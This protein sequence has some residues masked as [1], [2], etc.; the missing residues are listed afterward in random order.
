MEFDEMLCKNGNRD[1][2]NLILEIVLDFK[3]NLLLWNLSSRLETGLVM[4]IVSGYN[5]HMFFVLESYALNFC[6]WRKLFPLI[7]AVKT[8]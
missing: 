1:I 5:R 6:V 3:Y 2:K 8:S 4:E 7:N